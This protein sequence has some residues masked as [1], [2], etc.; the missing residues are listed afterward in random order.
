MYPEILSF[1]ARADF[2]WMEQPEVLLKGHRSS[3]TCIGQGEWVREQ[4][5]IGFLYWYF[6][7]EFSFALFIWRIEAKHKIPSVITIGEILNF[8]NIWHA[9]EALLLGEPQYMRRNLLEVFA[10]IQQSG[11]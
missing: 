6:S 8:L 10:E 5:T 7:N 4:V 11:Q 9:T 1:L 2:N 3:Y